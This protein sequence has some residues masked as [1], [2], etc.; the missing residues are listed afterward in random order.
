MDFSFTDEQQALRELAAKIF[1]DLCTH[2]RLRELEAAGECFDRSLWSE[3]AKANLLGVAIDEAHGGMGMGFLE[4]AQLLEEA[5]R[6]VAPVPLVPTLVLGALPIA[7][8]GSDAQRAHFLPRVA[9]GDAVLTAALVEPENE[10]PAA[11]DTVAAR[12]GD[13]WRLDGMKLSVP[14]AGQAERIAIPRSFTKC[15]TKKNR[16]RAEGDE[17]K[18][19]PDVNRRFGLNRLIQKGEPPAGGSPFFVS[20]R[21]LLWVVAMP[22]FSIAADA[23]SF[24]A[25][26]NRRSP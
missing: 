11:P 1:G 19:L 3:L 6:N 5:G 24:A 15:S 20:L 9:S 10:D 17:R 26:D 2:E 8:F 16:A 4:L 14:F 12:D 22:S 23:P 25:T 18:R 13:G 7:E 21:L